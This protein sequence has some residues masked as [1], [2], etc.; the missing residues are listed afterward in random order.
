MDT[1]MARKALQ[2]LGKRAQNQVAANESAGLARWYGKYS[3]EGLEIASK[4]AELD[5]MD[6]ILAKQIIGAQ[7]GLGG[8]MY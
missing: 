7:M 4:N 2:A 1:E 6:K 5:G 8:S 3:P